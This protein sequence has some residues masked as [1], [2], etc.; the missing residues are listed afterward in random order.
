MCPSPLIKGKDEYLGFALSE[1]PPFS[2]MSAPTFRS[3]KLSLKQQLRRAPNF[4]VCQTLKNGHYSYT[5]LHI[6]YCFS[7]V[8]NSYRN[9]HKIWQKCSLP[10]VVR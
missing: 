2:E 10:E 7:Q 9:G 8:S 3:E 5:S 4:F 1:A 6:I